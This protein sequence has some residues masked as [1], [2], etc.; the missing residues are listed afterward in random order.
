M[1]NRNLAMVF[2]GQ[3]SQSVG[4]LGELI[5]QR[6]IARHTIEEAS[7]I[8][9]LD[10]IQLL[11]NGPA[12]TLNRTEITQPVMLAADIA[13]WRVWRALGGPLPA[14]AAGHSLGEYAALVAAGSLDFS[15]GVGLVAER[16]R[17]MQAA[18]PAGQGAMAAVLGLDDDRVAEVCT[19]CSD[20]LGLVAPANYNAPGQVVIAGHSGAVQTACQALREAGARKT[21]LLPVSVPSH[22]VLMDAIADQFTAVLEDTEFRPPEFPVRHNLDGQPRTSG[23]D[24][25][26]AL[27][28]QLS[29]PVQWTRTIELLLG[30]SVSQFAECGPGR[31]LCGLIRRVDRRAA[32][33]A[34]ET[35]DGLAAALERGLQ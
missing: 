15:D 31:V 3:G 2:P 20:E 23:P 5:D 29:F 12:E 1:M 16:S 14:Q 35:A 22:C 8:L 9:D 25:R 33:D 21:L 13:V 4:M 28:R 19:A 11:A 7:D 18:V 27:A 26:Q 24:I 30:E 34:M 6:P 32:C 10:L 17:L